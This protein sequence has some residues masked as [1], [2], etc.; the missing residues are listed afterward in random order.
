LLSSPFRGG[1]EFAF[2]KWFGQLGD[3]NYIAYKNKPL[4]QRHFGG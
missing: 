4:P 3:I 2:L 1:D